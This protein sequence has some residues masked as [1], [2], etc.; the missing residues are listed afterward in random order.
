MA[1][2][3]RG[4]PAPTG[5]ADPSRIRPLPGGAGLRVVANPAA[6]G[7]ERALAELRS[8]LPRARPVTVRS[9]G[10]LPAALEAAA[11]SAAEAGGALG[12]VGGDGSV[13]AAARAALRHGLPLAVFPGGALDH[14]AGAAGLRSVSVAAT[15]VEEGRG[16][17]VD[18]ALIGTP[19]A[20]RPPRVFLN[21]FALGA[22]AD[23]V[24]FREL[25]RP[26]CGRRAATALALPFASG[27]AR[28]FALRLDGTPRR[29]WLLF[30]GN[31]VYRQH[32]LHALPT[33]ERLS[34]GLLDVRLLD[35]D[36][37]QRHGRLVALLAEAVDAPHALALPEQHVV[38]RLRLAGL[39][40]LTYAYDG[41]AAA[42][43]D[44]LT[45]TAA[46]AA[47]LLYRP[48]PSK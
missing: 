17:A 27:T 24:R 36:A 8:L 19:G 37:G 44:T 41:E 32:S 39:R 25:V 47:L 46:P 15:A 9:P 40:G 2:E 1:A 33:R 34:D 21:T 28:P 42:A 13:N 38:P 14:F 12:V 23:L 48:V 10:G 3:R 7:A 18:V 35:A 5:R 20:H 26:R 6:T 43:P 45:L 30:A 16:A 29:L 31:G 4:R 22:Y 11:R